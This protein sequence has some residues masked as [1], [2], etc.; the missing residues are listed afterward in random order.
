MTGVWGSRWLNQNLFMAFMVP[1]LIL[2]LQCSRLFALRCDSYH[3]ICKVIVHM[4]E[5][6]TL[7]PFHSQ[8]REIHTCRKQLGLIFVWLPNLDE[9]SLVFILFLSSQWKRKIGQLVPSS[10]FV[11]ELYIV[12]FWPTLFGP[13]QSKILWDLFQKVWTNHVDWDHN[14]PLAEWIMSPYLLNVAILV[15]FTAALIQV[16]RLF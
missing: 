1:Y 16:Q 2:E 4:C 6:I 15:I 3:L 14:N 8:W 9:M 13:K 7:H 11:I 5:L 10:I 12:C